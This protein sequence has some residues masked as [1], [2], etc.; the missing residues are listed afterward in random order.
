M[1]LDEARRRRKDYATYYH[2]ALLYGPLSDQEFRVAAYPGSIYH[3]KTSDA[4]RTAQNWWWNVWPTLLRRRKSAALAIQVNFRGFLQRRRWRAIIRL[5][6]LWGFT[7]IVAHAFVCWR[8]LVAKTCK[9]TV[10]ARRFR[11]RC[12]ARCL[13]AWA[14]HVDAE[15]KLREAIV[16]DLL[17]RASQGIRLRVF[18]AWA[19]YTDTSLAIERMRVRSFARPVLWAW[20]E[21]ASSD[22]LR[23]QLGWAC[24]KLTARLK[25]WQHRTG[26]LERRSACCT[27][28]RGVRIYIARVRLKRKITESRTSRALEIIQDVEVGIR[29]A[30]VCVMFFYYSL[31][32]IMPN[33]MRDSCCCLYNGLERKQ[34]E[35]PQY[36]EATCL[37]PR[38]LVMMCCT[39]P[40]KADTEWQRGSLVF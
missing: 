22:R 12:V 33:G 37:L 35:C 25:R 20:H 28:Q 21:Q 36:T 8:E 7:R 38:C 1:R 4:A 9:V 5:R 16:H 29:F 26:F 18:E 32:V 34:G 14:G 31:S 24:A 40:P 19:R 23:G 15:R 10:F 17:K 11:S 13:A 2:L 39:W 6:T 27:V 3:N 30:S